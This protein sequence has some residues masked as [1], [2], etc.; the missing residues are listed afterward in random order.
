M[1]RINPNRGAEAASTATGPDDA[2]AASP[3]FSPSTNEETAP[4]GQPSGV[5]GIDGAD[6]LNRVHHYAR[7]FIC[8]PS[9]TAGIVHVLWMAHTC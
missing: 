3:A 5:V 1:S 2:K 9:D 8:Y 6:L 4:D 7:R